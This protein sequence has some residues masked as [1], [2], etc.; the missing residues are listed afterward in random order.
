MAPSYGLSLWMA[1]E[2]IFAMLKRGL[3]TSQT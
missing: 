1:I 2:S 3:C